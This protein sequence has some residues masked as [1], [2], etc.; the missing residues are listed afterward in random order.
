MRKRIRILFVV[1]IVAVVGGIGW[2]VWRSDEPVYEGRT[3][4][5]WLKDY[6]PPMPLIARGA[7]KIPAADNA[8]RQIGSNA[9]PALLHRLRAK[10]SGLVHRFVA[11]A[12]KLRVFKMKQVPAAIQW[13]EGYCGFR[14]LGVDG[15]EAVPELIEI[16]EWNNLPEARY[17]IAGA[18]GA[19]G[20]AA[21]A[22]VPALIRGIG[23][24]GILSSEAVDA[25][26]E[27]HSEPELTV[28]VLLKYLGRDSPFRRDAAVALAHFGADA[29]PA[30]PLL[31]EMI[32]NPNDSIK[33]VAR[34]ALIEIAAG[35]KAQNAKYARIAV[36]ILVR[37]L[38]DQRIWVRESAAHALIFFGSSAKSA[39]PALI[40]LLDDPDPWVRSV[41]R[42]SLF[43]IDAEAAA[44]SGLNTRWLGK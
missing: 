39:G 38:S 31:L 41:A 30:V 14:A 7:S 40:R 34:E 23:K 32:N 27:I 12:L 8:V 15:K 37:C 33:K 6:D 28:P 26:G 10:D 42:E 1:L 25:L 2:V 43:N 21:K 29:K 5:E 17:A 3:L 19:I 11:L 22:A 9:I 36:P 44:H 18:L 4:S 24:N 35:V 20:P 13:Q 16:Y